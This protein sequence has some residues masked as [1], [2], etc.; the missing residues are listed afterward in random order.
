MIRAVERHREGETIVAAD[1]GNG[2]IRLLMPSPG[3]FLGRQRIEIA[4]LVQ[5]MGVA[6]IGVN[7]RHHGNGEQRGA[8][9]NR[10]QIDR[11][12]P[13]DPITRAAHHRNHEQEQALHGPQ[14]R[15]VG[16]EPDRRDR[17]KHD[18]RCANQR[19]Q[20]QAGV[21]GA[22]IAGQFLEAIDRHQR[23]D[24]RRDRQ[25]QGDAQDEQQR[26]KQRSTEGLAGVPRQRIDERLGAG[27]H[28]PMDMG[29]KR[30]DHGQ[31]GNPGGQGR[32]IGAPLR[33]ADRSD[34]EAE[35]QKHRIIF[36]EHRQRRRGTGGD[37]PSD[38]AGFE[39]AQE[40]IGG[41]RP[42]RQQHRVGVEA[43]GVKLVDRQQHQQQQHDDAFVGAG[44]TARNQIDRPQRDRRIGQRH[45]LERPVGERKHRGPCA[46]HPAH[47][48]RMFRVAPFDAASE[49]PGFQHVGMQIAADIGDHQERQPYNDESDQQQRNAP[50]RLDTIHPIEERLSPP[51]RRYFGTRGHRAH[52][53][54]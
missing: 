14:R 52:R 47:Q 41:D 45:Q 23:P 3:Q 44:E 8:D 49:R 25:D 35:D 53:Q 30:C 13:F 18:S 17:R 36:A 26:L 24:R 37:G 21:H 20:Q 27:R 48:R 28:Q 31:D 6:I 16:A 43:L 42:G 40:A 54:E 1:R 32:E 7:R 12:K 22:D 4:S 29:P 11:I 2:G 19:Q 9:H 10:R 38:R 51:R 46:R 33:M 39:R 50:A 5:R 15:H 34:E